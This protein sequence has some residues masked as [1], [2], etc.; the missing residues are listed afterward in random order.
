MYLRGGINFI[1][2]GIT[3]NLRAMHLQT[4]L[5]AIT[6]ENVTGFDKVGYQRKDPVVSSFSEFMGVHG[7][8]TAVDDAVGRLA[9]SDNPLDLSLANKG[10]FQCL[11]K[12]GI[13]LTRDG[14]F[15]LDMN[16]NLLNLSDEKILANDGTPI[17]LPFSPDKLEDVKIDLDGNVRVFN[18]KTNKLDYVSTVSV[19]TN[20]GVAVLAPNVRQGYNEFSNVSLATEFM[21]AMPIV[22]NF[23][24]NRQLFQMQTN[25]L[26]KAIQQ[27]GS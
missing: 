16:G 5:M 13:K 19:V 3:A 23:D 27:L 1:E 11:G 17:K 12:E 18:K 14:R 4:E 25:T 8:S 2:N 26:S 7:L 21:Q 15:K 10:Y 6:N 22:R 24:A 9:V 20:S